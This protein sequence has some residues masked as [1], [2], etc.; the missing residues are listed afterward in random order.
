MTFSIRAD[1]GVVADHGSAV[2]TAGNLDKCSGC[3]DMSE[4]RFIRAVYCTG[5]VRVIVDNRNAL[6]C[7]SCI[8]RSSIDTQVRDGHISCI[9]E[10]NDRTGRIR[11]V[12][13]FT[14]NVHNYLCIRRTINDDIG[15]KFYIDCISICCMNMCFL[16]SIGQR[17]GCIANCSLQS[18]PIYI[19]IVDIGVTAIVDAMPC[20]A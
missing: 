3:N 6:S 10:V 5:A 11:L 2:V 8:Q 17:L 15:A 18:V 13:S 20:A 12:R 1:I 14:Y 16:S 7:L 9:Q 19:I 4:F